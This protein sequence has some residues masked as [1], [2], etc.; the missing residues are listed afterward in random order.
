MS[1]QRYSL[2]FRRMSSSSMSIA[3]LPRDA[4]GSCFNRS[5]I[6]QCHHTFVSPSR[7]SLMTVS[8]CTMCWSRSQDQGRCCAPDGP[9]LRQ[10]GPR[11]RA[12]HHAAP[13]RSQLGV[14]VVALQ[15]L[16]LALQ[17]VARAQLRSS[18]QF[19]KCLSTASVP[20]MSA[21]GTPARMCCPH[22]LSRQHKQAE[23]LF[24]AA[25]AWPGYAMP[26]GVAQSVVLSRQN[27]HQPI[28]TCPLPATG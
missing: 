27:D 22:V 19:S 28:S 1:S 25:A 24:C 18:A 2:V 11:A 23:Q 14:H 6:C 5:L 10:R 3:S 16:E 15:R 4:K 7:M 17:R 12:A 13:H 21:S 26:P 20:C 9:P 8:T